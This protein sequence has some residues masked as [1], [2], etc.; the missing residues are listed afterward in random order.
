ML[1]QRLD[2]EHPMAGPCAD[3]GLIVPQR[4][5]CVDGMTHSRM[6]LC[7][8]CWRMFRQRQVFA[9]GCCG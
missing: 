7:E 9:G 6:E 8:T 3:C 2:T 5:A 1:A 4:I